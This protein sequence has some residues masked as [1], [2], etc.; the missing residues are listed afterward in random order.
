MSRKKVFSD[1]VKIHALWPIGLNQSRKN[2]QG[3]HE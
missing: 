2:A 3:A 1:D